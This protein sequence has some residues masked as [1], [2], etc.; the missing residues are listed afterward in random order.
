MPEAMRTGSVLPRLETAAALDMTPAVAAEL[1]DGFVELCG[2]DS[3]GSS[4]L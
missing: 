1:W 3:S 2:L 4:R